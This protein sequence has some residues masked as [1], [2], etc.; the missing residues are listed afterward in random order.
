V[1]EPEVVAQHV[2]L[3]RDGVDQPLIEAD[4]ISGKFPVVLNWQTNKHRIALGV[5]E[6]HVCDCSSSSFVRFDENDWVRLASQFVA[7]DHVFEF[8]R[9]RRSDLKRLNI[10]HRGSLG[11]HHAAQKRIL[12]SVVKVNIEQ[13]HEAE[14]YQAA[15]RCEENFEQR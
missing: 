14:S 2:V 10:L 13:N 12:R 11:T 15:T 9:E 8:L 7:G 5:A 6:D 3:G 1:I 4:R